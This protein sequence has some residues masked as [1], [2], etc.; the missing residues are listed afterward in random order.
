MDTA[1]AVQKNS[2][3]ICKLSWRVAKEPPTSAL[4]A[5]ILTLFKMTER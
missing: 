3:L 2:Q 1:R 4:I 5:T